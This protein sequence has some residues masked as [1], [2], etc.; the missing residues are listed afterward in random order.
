MRTHRV[1]LLSGVFVSAL[2]VFSV[3]IVKAQGVTPRITEAVDN[4]KRVALRGNTYPLARPENDRGAAPDSLPMERMLLVLTRSPEQEAA[5]TTLL[6][7]QQDKSSPNFHRWLTPE[8]FGQQFG[9]ADADIQAVTGWLTSQGFRVNSVA[10]GRTHRCG[11][12][13]RFRWR[14]E[15]GLSLPD[16]HG[17]FI[18]SIQLPS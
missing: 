16:S 12:S 8:Q 9:P 5:L 1:V 2:L 3:P 18:S 17:D 6:D 11:H 10:K 4:E 13:P 15:T 14:A 7:E